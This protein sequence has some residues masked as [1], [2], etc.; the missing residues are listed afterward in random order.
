MAEEVALN[1]NMEVKV[2]E[3]MTWISII[4]VT[5]LYF[6]ELVFAGCSSFIETRFHFSDVFLTVEIQLLEGGKGY[7]RD[8]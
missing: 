5:G 3:P 8:S 4:F 2:C 1:D 7:F 6:D